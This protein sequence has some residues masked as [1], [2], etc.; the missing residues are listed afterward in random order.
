MSRSAAPTLRCRVARSKVVSPRQ[1][2]TN[3]FHLP[4]VARLAW[5]TIGF[6]R[7]AFRIVTPARISETSVPATARSF[8][9]RDRDA[10]LG[11][12]L[13]EFMLVVVVGPGLGDPAIAD[14]EHQHRW[15]ANSASVSFGVRAVQPNGMLVV[16]HH[17]ME[18]GPEGPARPLSLDPPSW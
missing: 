6:L 17:V 7:N 9:D 8:P 14:M 12:E 2:R 15:T 5:T 13:V 18:G 11:P 3:W 1:N 4:G 10:D 16:G